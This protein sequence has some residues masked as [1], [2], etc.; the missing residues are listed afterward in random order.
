MRATHK[1]QYTDAMRQHAIRVIAGQPHPRIFGAARFFLDAADRYFIDEGVHHPL[2]HTFSKTDDAEVIEKFFDAFQQ[3][4]ISANINVIKAP[5]NLIYLDTNNETM[6]N[7]SAV[8]SNIRTPK[9]YEARSFCTRNNP[10]C[11]FVLFGPDCVDKDHPLLTGNSEAYAKP[12]RTMCMRH[13]KKT[14]RLQSSGVLS[15]DKADQLM[16]GA[17]AIGNDNSIGLLPS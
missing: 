5:K 4:L 12:A 9:W 1:R 10:A 13:D 15:S 6:H 2:I 17:G 8:F 7:K 3:A 16:I 14:R 11:G